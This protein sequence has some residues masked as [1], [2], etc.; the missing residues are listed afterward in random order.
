MDSFITD[1]DSEWMGFDDHHDALGR[2][3]SAISL[4]AF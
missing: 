2:Q 1:M 3:D 4:G